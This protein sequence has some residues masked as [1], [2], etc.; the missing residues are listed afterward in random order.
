[1]ITVDVIYKAFSK[2]QFDSRSVYIDYEEPNLEGVTLTIKARIVSPMQLSIRELQMHPVRGEKCEARL[3]VSNTTEQPWSDLRVMAS[4]SWLSFNVLPVQ[5]T[6]SE[7]WRQSWN[8]VVTVETEALLPGKDKAVIHFVSVDGEATYEDRIPLEVLT[9]GDYEIIPKQVHLGTRTPGEVVS[10]SLLLHRSRVGP[11]TKDG[12]VVIQDD[13]SCN[14]NSEVTHISE[15]I[16]K[17]T[18]QIGVPYAPGYHKFVL[19]VGLQ[20]ARGGLLEIPVS[21]RVSEPS[22]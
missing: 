9:K 19:K 16:D 18:L 8:V 13:G 10:S 4:E 15:F 3:L 21:M 5:S 14:T 11:G 1:M 7:E 6:S 22:P 12:N 2:S 17:I 20:N